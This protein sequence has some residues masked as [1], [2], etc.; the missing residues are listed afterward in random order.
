MK[1]NQLERVSSIQLQ[2]NQSVTFEN[3]T[4]ESG[5]KETVKDD[6]L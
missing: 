1:N 3:F 4:K 6:L 2:N 5:F